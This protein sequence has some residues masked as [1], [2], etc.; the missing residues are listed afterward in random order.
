MVS[1]RE[2]FDQLNA[3]Y[4]SVHK[5]KEDLFWATYMAT[6]SDDEGFARAE[7]A[8]KNFISDTERLAALRQ[9]LAGLPG[10]PT[11]SSVRALKVGLE[12]WLAL[13]ESNI[14][15]NEPARQHMASLIGLEARLFA[16][17]RDLVLEHVGASGQIEVATLG[18]L[19]T[20]MQTHRSTLTEMI[21]PY[22]DRLAAA[23]IDPMALSTPAGL[24]TAAQ[25]DGLVNQ[26][27]MMMAYVDDFRLMLFITL[28]A[29]PLILLLRF[30]RQPPGA[31]HS[32]PPAA[33][34][35]D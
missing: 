11:D 1:A 30:R 15:D 12:G 23:G 17:R 20:N 14:I 10:E 2:L 33:A 26:Q 32:G 31:G 3:D 28:A 25:L 27:A 9:A 8:Y 16:K 24:Q 22:G 4:S 19:T 29:V 6:S 7:E 5:T 13:F 18:T 34:M 35:A 21:T